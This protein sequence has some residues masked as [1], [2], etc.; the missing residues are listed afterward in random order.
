MSETETKTEALIGLETASR[1]RQ[2]PWLHHSDTEPLFL[3]CAYLVTLRII[4]FLHNVP[5][6]TCTFIW[7]DTI[8]SCLIIVLRCIKSPPSLLRYLNIV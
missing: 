5:V 8:S 3:N 6:L 1:P 2:Y 4:C 7:V